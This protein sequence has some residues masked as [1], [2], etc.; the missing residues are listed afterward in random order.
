MKLRF[1]SLLIMGFAVLIS[2]AA[3]AEDNSYGLL[4]SQK[5][6]NDPF[7]L[8]KQAVEMNLVKTLNSLEPAAGPATSENSK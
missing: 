4:A 2:S 1:F 3:K 5:S 7:Q 8:P 6:D